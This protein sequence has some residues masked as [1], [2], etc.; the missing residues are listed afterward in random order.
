MMSIRNQFVL[1]ISVSIAVS[2]GLLLE[3]SIGTSDFP[4][5]LS[6]SLWTSIG[7]AFFAILAV[8]FSTALR[9]VIALLQEMIVW[10]TEDSSLESAS[11]IDVISWLGGINSLAFVFSIY[12]AYYFV[13]AA[14]DESFLFAIFG[15]LMSMTF[16]VTQTILLSLMVAHISKKLED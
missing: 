5:A 11:P 3:I 12:L 8:A 16:L 4:V 9:L 1:A 13:Q 10:Q 2:I 14:V 15:Y 6:H 7:M